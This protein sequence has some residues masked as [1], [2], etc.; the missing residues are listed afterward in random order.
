MR[1]TARLSGFCSLGA[2]N[3]SVIDFDSDTKH[4]DVSFACYGFKRTLIIAKIFCPNDMVIPSE[5]R[6]LIVPI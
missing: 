4:S 6:I 5:Q 2:K 3:V 1:F